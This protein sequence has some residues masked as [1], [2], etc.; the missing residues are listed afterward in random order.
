MED[1]PRGWLRYTETTWVPRVYQCQ[2]DVR[3]CQAP[4]GLASC[5][6]PVFCLE[7]GIVIEPVVNRRPVEGVTG[8]PLSLYNRSRARVWSPI[9]TTSMRDRGYL[10]PE[11]VSK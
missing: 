1:A 11:E 8:G 5:S 4:V 7:R 6:C 10:S 9:P 2:A 3:A